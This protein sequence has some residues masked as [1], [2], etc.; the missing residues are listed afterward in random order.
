LNR[1]VFFIA[2]DFGLTAG[3]CAGITRAAREGVVRGTSALPCAPGT[4]QRIRE[5]APRTNAKLGVHLQLTEGTPLLPASQV[6]SLVRDEGRFPASLATLGH[7]QTA[8]VLA[9][10]HAQVDHLQ[11]LG[12]TVCHV[13]AH[14]HA[15][16]H[17]AAAQAYL[18][19]ARQRSLR[20]RALHP[21]VA[22]ELRRQGVASAD[23]CVSWYG[24]DRSVAGLVATIETAFET[25]GGTHLEVMCHPGIVDPDL[26]VASRYQVERE[27]ELA[28]LCDPE[29]PVILGRRGIRIT[30]PHTS[31]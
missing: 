7:L 16:K 1:R 12:V 5:W 3:V 31:Q 2:D 10:W 8:E 19:L 23:G 22:A 25:T 28:I 24:G 13:D 4:T 26:V 21:T 18:T 11:G 17:P 29:L 20:A 15:F 14:H 6:P 27:E 9:E 30:S